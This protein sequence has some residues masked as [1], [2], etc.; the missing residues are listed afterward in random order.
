M[1]ILSIMP[2]READKRLPTSN[3]N[4]ESA[5][6]NDDRNHFP[7]VLDTQ[8]CSVCKTV[9][10][11]FAKSRIADHHAF[12]AGAD[13]VWIIVEEYSH[14]AD[15]T[16]DGVFAMSIKIIGLSVQMIFIVT[17]DRIASS[18]PDGLGSRRAVNRR[19]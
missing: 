10:H 14:I 6:V 9:V 2:R 5:C 7:L 12:H 18:I 16:F 4:S 19:G 13:C 3:Q 17:W 1:V 11:R 8:R 15:C